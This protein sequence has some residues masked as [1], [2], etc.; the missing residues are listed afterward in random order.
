MAT[1]LALIAA[2]YGIP[3]ALGFSMYRATVSAL[4]VLPRLVDT[5]EIPRTQK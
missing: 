5:V 4:S 1:V 3:L 2:T